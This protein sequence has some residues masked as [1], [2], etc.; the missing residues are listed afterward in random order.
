M[1]A[2]ASY[3]SGHRLFPDV[4]IDTEKHP[5]LSVGILPPSFSM[6]AHVIKQLIRQGEGALVEFKRTLTHL[7]KVAKTLTAL[8]NSRGG[9]VLIGVDDNGQILGINPE[10]ESFMVTQAAQHYVQPAL[11]L[12]LQE[13]EFDGQTVLAV[14]VPESHLKPHQSRD[15]HDVWHTYIRTDDKCL[16]MDAES[17]RLLRQVPPADEREDRPFTHNEQAALELIKRQKRI[18]PKDLAKARNL[19]RQRAEKLLFELVREGHLY[20]HKEGPHVWYRAT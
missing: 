2:H 1:L 18:T 16:A 20:Q 7:P 17:I 14:F 13:Y 15:K 19:S 5:T 4:P 9:V 8:A 6:D 11:H 12:S 3:I 10:E